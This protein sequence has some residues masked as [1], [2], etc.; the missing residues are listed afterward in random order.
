MYTF[1]QIYLELTYFWLF[2]HPNLQYNIHFVQNQNSYQISV[3]TRRITPVNY[4]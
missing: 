4:D 2:V 1:Q 3:Q